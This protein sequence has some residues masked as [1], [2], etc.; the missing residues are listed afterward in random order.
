RLDNCPDVPGWPENNGC[1]EKQLVAINGCKIDLSKKI[2]FDTGRTVVKSRSYKMLNNLAQVLAA[3]KNIKSLR[4][5]GHTDDRGAASFNKQLSQQRADAV[6]IYL[7]EQG[8]GPERLEAI[9]FGEERPVESNATR[10]G[11]ENNRRVEL[12]IGDCDESQFE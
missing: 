3:Q 4:I 9:G 2:Y 5:E 6:R 7:E 8:I 1:K 10:R 11:R 12:I